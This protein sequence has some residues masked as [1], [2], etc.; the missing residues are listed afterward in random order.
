MCITC[1]CSDST[2]VRLTDLEKGGTIPINVNDQSHEHSHEHHG[3]SHE[4]HDHSHEHHDH[5]HEHHGHSHEHHGHSH[6][7]LGETN[8]TNTITLE[9]QIL[10]KNNS[11]A[12]SNRD[13]LANKNILAVNLVS[14][15]GSGKTTLLERTIRD[16]SSELQFSVIEGDQETVNDAERIRSTGCRVVQINTGAGCHLEADMVIKG[17]H[18]L[19]PAPN[20]VIMIEN[21]GNLVCPALFDL[22]EKCKVA[23]LSVTEGE[24]KPAKYPHMFKAAS[25]M[26][27][28][29]IDLLPYL[30][31]DVAKCIEYAKTVNPDIKVIPVSAVSGEGLDIWF[32]WI[33]SN[34]DGHSE[35]RKVAGL[36]DS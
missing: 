35:D 32:A 36:R 25:I 10:E 18:S 4:H 2:N 5:S 33:K 14:S 8:P 24:D 27:L 22:G 1:G 30:E 6:E 21:V 28:N 34:I 31:F 11:I 17:I 23:I 20:S 13:W 15:P 29:K 16:L 12:A 9:R 26:L 3:H 19:D 7:H